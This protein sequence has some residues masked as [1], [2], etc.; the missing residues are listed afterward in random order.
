MRPVGWFAVLLAISGVVAH[1]GHHADV[2]V[3][4]EKISLEPGAAH[5]YLERAIRE[6]LMGNPEGA[7]QDL[8]HAALLAPSDA[9]ILAER[10]LALAE[11]G[12]DVEADADLTRSLEDAHPTA[13]V[14][15]ARARLRASA[16]RLDEAIVDYSGA[17]ALRPDPDLYLARGRLLEKGGR[18]VEA[19]QGYREGLERLSGA[20]SLRDALVQVEVAR[21]SFQSALLL[22]DEEIARA[23]L[24]TRAYLQRA[25]ILAAAGFTQDAR[26][27]L[28][29]AVEEHQ[30]GG[31]RNKS[32]LARIT[33]VRAL[34]E[35]A[36]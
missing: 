17:I 12:C 20:A 30:R 8:D 16:G 7:L 14:F 35:V 2:A 21:G 24:K 9:R 34:L 18:L 32:S 4:T 13:P 25:E 3:L 22:L 1:P 36:R 33:R 11:L 26:A 6:R 19:A 27:D 31:G 10:G 28:E 23:P 5:L 15:A 29:R